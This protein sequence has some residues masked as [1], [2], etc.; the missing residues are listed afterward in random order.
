MGLVGTADPLLSQSGSKGIKTQDKILI[1]GST[2]KKGNI[3]LQKR[4]SLLTLFLITKT[5]SLPWYNKHNVTQL[6][7]FVANNNTF[8][9]QGYLPHYLLINLYTFL[10]D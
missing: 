3:P 1:S 5:V 7:D 10:R 6:Y 2:K 4:P 8:F 9:Q